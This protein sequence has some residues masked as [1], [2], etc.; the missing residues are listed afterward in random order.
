MT[1]KVYS[2]PRSH[3]FLSIYGKGQ[4]CSFRDEESWKVHSLRGLVMD[5]PEISICD[6]LL[7]WEKQ[8]LP[9]ERETMSL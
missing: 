7:A 3:T 6:V 2:K 9:Q 5:K 1:Q 8:G 4:V